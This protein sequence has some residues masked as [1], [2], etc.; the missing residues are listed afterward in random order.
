MQLIVWSGCWYGVAIV[1]VV[2]ITV[3]V[4]FFTSVGL[5]ML[6]ALL[7]FRCSAFIFI[8]IFAVEV[9]FGLVCVLNCSTLEGWWRYCVYTFFKISMWFFF[10]CIQK[11]CCFSSI[12]FFLF[13]QILIQKKSSRMK[14][15]PFIIH[16]RTENDPLSSLDLLIL[17]D[18]NSGKSS[19]RTETDSLLP[20]HVSLHYFC[21]IWN[22]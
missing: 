22:I 18:M 2:T 16:E 13:W 6:S 7:E 1:N 4:V 8:Y 14:K 20:F 11:I 21:I 10:F 3:S 19:W 9:L 12:I 5:C 15:W 17:V